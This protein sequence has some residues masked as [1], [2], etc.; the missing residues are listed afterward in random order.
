M[1]LT[2]RSTLIL[3]AILLMIS[4]A[5]VLAQ[6]NPA[7]PAPARESMQD[8]AVKLSPQQKQEFVDARKA[9]GG[10]CYGDALPIFK[11]LLSQLPGD[12][13]LSKFAGEAALNV[14]DTSFALTTL[15]PL[16]QSD[17]DDWQVAALLTRACAESGDMPCRDS[18]MAHMLDLHSRGIT[19][20]R[21]QQYIV[22]RVKVG[23]NSLLIRVSVEPWGSYKVYAFGQVLDNDGKKISHVTVESADFDQPIFAKDH[24]EEAAKGV[25]SFSMD[26]YSEIGVNSNG[27][28]TQTHSTIKFFVGQPS[29]DTIR[30]GFVNFASGKAAPLTKSTHVAAP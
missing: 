17:P 10:E 29:Y 19:P 3:F 22:E 2:S 5:L 30:E 6:A 15:K 20:P 12:A 23:G 1:T 21:L 26:G 25:R 13:V 28:R 8:L 11:Q 9:F 16:A 7:A 18:G 24:P 27:Q 4:P 14:G